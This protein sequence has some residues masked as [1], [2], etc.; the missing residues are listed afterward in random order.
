MTSVGRKALRVGLIGYGLAGR[1][2]HAPLVS[3]TDGLELA[4]IVT[5]NPARAAAAHADHPGAAVLATAEALWAI[6]RDL[7][8]VV[9]A[10]PNRHHG[11]LAMAA[12]GAGLPVVID[13][14]MAPTAAEGRAIIGEARRLGLPISV[15]Q[16]RRWD[17]DFLTVLRLVESGEL[18]PVRRFESRFERWQPKIETGWRESG[19]DGD[20]GGVLFDLGPHL[21]DQAV[22]LLGPATVA[23][24]EVGRHRPSVEVDDDAFVALEHASGARSHLWMGA[25]VPQLG[26]RLR[27]LGERA[28]YTKYGLDVQ[29][30]SL[31]AG[32]R[33]GDP[34]FGEDPPERWGL[35]GAEGDLRPLRTERG[36]YEAYYAGVVVALRDGAP[37]PVDAADS[38]AVLELIE[39]AHRLASGGTPPRY[40]E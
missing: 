28:G 21:I 7:D 15:F 36:R 32:G 26:P 29:E 31:A 10:T 13:K 22:R 25:A 4:A 12:L 34:G 23:Y 11:V 18:G 38:V 20:A 27:V 5:A 1:V 14:P 3:T 40:S 35:V 9:V 30:D 33:P 2:F 16:N 19:T 17:G 24:A 37:M 39:A 8:L 6:G